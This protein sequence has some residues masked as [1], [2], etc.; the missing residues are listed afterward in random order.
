MN[1]SDIFKTKVEDGVAIL[2]IDMVKFSTNLFTK[3]FIMAFSSEGKKHL[4][5]EDIKGLILTSSKKDFMAGADLKSMDISKQTKDEFFAEMMQMHEAFRGLE[6]IE[7]P[8]VACINGNALGGGL[9]A[10]L[11]A[12]YRIAMDGNYKIGFPEIQVGLFPG[13]GGVIKSCYLLGIQ[14]AATQILQAKQYKPQKAKS[15][16]FIDQIVESKEELI[17]EAKKWIHENP[18]A[19]QPWDTKGYK[20]PGGALQT[21]KVL[22]I[23]AAT[24]ANVTKN[25]FGNYPAT[26]NAVSAIYHGMQM[27]FDRALEVEARWFT[28]SFYSKEAQHMIRTLFINGEAAKKGKYKPQGYDKKEYKKI[29]VLGAGMMGAGVAYVSAKAGIEVIL[30]DVS[31]ESADKGKEYSEKLLKKSVSRGKMTQEKMDDILDRITATTELQPIQGADLVIEAVFEN[32]ELK[33]KVTQET[34]GFLA[35]DGIWGSNTSTLPITGL[36]KASSKPNRFIGVHFFSPVEKMPLVE[37]IKGKETDEKTVSETVDYVSKIG[38]YPIVVND[39]RG[40]FTSRVFGTL[41]SEAS[42]MLME[43]VSPARL[44]NIARNAGLP[45]GPLAVSDEISFDLPLYIWE[46]TP[47]EL[48]NGEGVTDASLIE[49]INK[50]LAVDSE[51]RGKKVG[52]GFYNY[53]G[54]KKVLWGGLKDIFPSNDHIDNQTVADRLLYRMSLE[55]YRCLDEGV[56]DRVEDGDIGGIFGL[57]FPPF[58]GGPLSF[59]DYVGVEKYVARLDELAA[60]FGKRFQA[61]AS[62]RERAKTGQGMYNKNQPTELV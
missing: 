11:V 29:A 16:G 36:A 28:K 30:K 12:N 5:Q 47:E 37:I 49:V 60:Q 54:N 61:P 22:P 56:L 42:A 45:V 32:Q 6:K 3:D 48:K 55:T 21:A 43:G 35:E 58:T 14:E 57:G 44:E 10:A 41:P 24:I 40:F 52:K 18:S 25:S 15:V 39:S 33:H 2:S 13:G 38:K 26:Y 53:E 23:I 34:E 20:I 31:Q 27:P 62:L 9:E 8:V 1:T 59:I 46:T 51:R 50:I 17:A 7:K 19:K 4:E